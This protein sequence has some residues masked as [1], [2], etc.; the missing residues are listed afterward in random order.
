[1]SKVKIR[2]KTFA[3]FSDGVR[4]DTEFFTIYDK[5]ILHALGDRKGK[6]KVVDNLII[7]ATFKCDEYVLKFNKDG[8]S[9][10][11]VA[12]LYD[13]PIRMQIGAYF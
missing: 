10:V 2:G 9:A 5:G 3:W 6:W 11:C 13:P 12:P 8:K 7:H 1:M 4:C